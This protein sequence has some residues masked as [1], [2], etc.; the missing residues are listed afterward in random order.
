MRLPRLYAPLAILLLAIA[1]SAESAKAAWVPGS[2]EMSGGRVIVRRCPNAGTPVCARITNAGVIHLLYDLGGLTWY[3]VS[4]DNGKTF[5]KA[6]CT[7]D[8]N[9]R[10]PGLE[11]SGADMSVNNNG[12]VF[13]AMSTNGWKLK[14]PQNEWSLHYTTL[15]PGAS[16]FSPVSNLNG[17]SSQGFSLASDDGGNV[18]AVWL[19]EKLY[20]NFSRDGGKTFSAN[21]EISNECD[22]CPCCTTSSVF[23]AN[24]DLAVLYRE[25]AG[26][27]RDMFILIRHRDGRISRKRIST[28]LWNI[29]A[30][31]MSCFTISRAGEGYVAAWPTKG[32][33]YFVKLDKDGNQLPPGEIATDGRAVSHE[34]ILALATPD[35]HILIAWNH[36]SRLNWQAFTANGRPTGW[37]E[38]TAEDGKWAAGVALADSRILLFQ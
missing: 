18:A 9:S 28:T 29:D 36:A 35:G 20:A 5:E 12:Q 34:G 16:A 7:V 10:Q 25:E 33:V 15:A 31:P 8:P 23:G 11:F 19:S 27:N 14:V 13:V 3:T 6:I 4:R 2:D 22:P 37:V 38:S 30:C 17:K 24:G 1:F 21:A 26:N 32:Q